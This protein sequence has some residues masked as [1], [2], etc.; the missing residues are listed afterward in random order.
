MHVRTQINNL[1]KR[2]A[3]L[4]SGCQSMNDCNDL[5]NAWQLVT[6]SNLHR[7]CS[8][9]NKSLRILL[10][11]FSKIIIQYTAQIQCIFRLSLDNMKQNDAFMRLLQP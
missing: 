4:Q 2:G 7:K 5:D 3:L 9:S 6:Q 1:R 10:H 8:K 11:N